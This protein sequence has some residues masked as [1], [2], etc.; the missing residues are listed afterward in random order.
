MY[1]NKDYNWFFDKMQTKWFFSLFTLNVYLVIG[2][3]HGILFRFA[4]LIFRSVASASIFPL[5]FGQAGRASG[6]GPLDRSAA[7]G[8]LCH[9][10][11]ET[12]S[13]PTDPLVSYQINQQFSGWYL[14]PLVFGAVE[15]T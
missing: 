4:G 9:E 7:R 8:G 10:G 15:P 1:I 6:R 14:P 12:A 11:F 5:V 2:W 13:C 3:D